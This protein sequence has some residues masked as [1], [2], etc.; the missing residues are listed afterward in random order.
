MIKRKER[1]Y[2]LGQKVLDTITGFKGTITAVAD[3]YNGCVRYQVQP[4]INEKGEYQ[5]SVMVDEEQLELIPKEKKPTVP[6]SKHGGDRPAL[7]KYK[8]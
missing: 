5:D 7:P 1:K 4:P 6:K 2:E 3:Y 8:L